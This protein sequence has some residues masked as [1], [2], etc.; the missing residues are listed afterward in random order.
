MNRDQE[1]TRKVQLGLLGDERSLGNVAEPTGN[2]EASSEASISGYSSVAESFDEYAALKALC[3]DAA[4]VVKPLESLAKLKTKDKDV[5]LALRKALA[6]VSKG[7]QLASAVD[8]LKERGERLLADATK[9][10]AEAFRRVEAGFIRATKQRGEVARE[11]GQ[12]TWRV[13]LLE[14]QVRRA[15]AK[16]RVLYNRESLGAWQSIGSSED[17][18][19]LTT[20]G[21]RSL[22]AAA[23]PAI[24]FADALWEAYEFLKRQRPQEPGGAVRIPLRELYRETRV[25]LVRQELKTGKPDHKLVRWVD[26]PLWAFL[27]N[28][29]LYRKSLVNVPSDR[30]LALETGSQQDHQR[31]LGL[32][33][34]GL[35]P[36]S[37]YKSYCYAY[38]TQT[39]Q[40]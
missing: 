14:L 34:N 2:P 1:S 21:M 20:G 16:A 8:E 33:L 15:E 27:H 30:R 9:A 32:I 23:I 17:L 12:E 7:E 31:G 18:E 22:E 3:R 5:L 35:D 24:E 39:G 6:A 19:E 37:D 38:A 11:V 36:D 29:D 13:G 10:R 4:A 40:R 26:V 25:V 28:L